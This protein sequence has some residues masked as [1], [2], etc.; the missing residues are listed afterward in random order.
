MIKSGILHLSLIP[1]FL[2]AGTVPQA[3]AQIS[4]DTVKF[5]ADL[6][7]RHE[8]IEAEGKDQRNRERIR[9]RLNMTARL[10]DEVILG[11]QIASGT[12]NP[13]SS[14]QTLDGGFSSKQDL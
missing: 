8:L 2:F 3:S 1:M 10:N 4:A 6:R 9:A 14:N 7:Y 5:G 11:F 13:V 12:D